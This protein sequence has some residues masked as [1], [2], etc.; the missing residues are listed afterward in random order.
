M[1]TIPN[2]LRSNAG[3]SRPF[4]DVIEPFP[5]AFDLGIP[6]SRGFRVRNDYGE[7]IG[8]IGVSHF[9][10]SP[11]DFLTEMQLILCNQADAY[12][13]RCAELHQYIIAGDG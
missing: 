8:F 12:L 10:C 3:C 7:K 11:H 2:P 6:Y 13:K 9:Y 5:T 1:E 4:R